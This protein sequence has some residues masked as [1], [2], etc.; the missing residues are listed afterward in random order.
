MTTAC[1]ISSRIEGGAIAEF[2]SVTLCNHTSA[3][4][5]V[6]PGRHGVLANVF[7]DRVTGRRV[8]PNDATTWHR[9]AEWLRPGGWFLASMGRSDDAG[10]NEENFLGFGHTNWTNGYDPDTSRR[11]L[12]EAGFELEHAVVVS[13]A[14]PFG[15]ER[16]LWVLGRRRES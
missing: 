2:P 7:Y 11:L 1:R 13:E 5:G 16:W 9:S 15:P 3:L 8:V 4:T 10:W 12:V 14:T 6:G